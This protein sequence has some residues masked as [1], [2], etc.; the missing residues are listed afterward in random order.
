VR[1]RKERLKQRSGP[2]GGN[3]Q[4]LPIVAVRDEAGVHRQS[5]T[6]KPGSRA[7]CPSRVATGQPCSTATAAIHKSFSGIGVPARVKEAFI[8]P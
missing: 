5:C 2:P 1:A 3:L 6:T 7:K 8:Y 4:V